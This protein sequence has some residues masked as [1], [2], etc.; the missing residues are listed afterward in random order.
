[1]AVATASQPLLKLLRPVL[2]ILLII[3]IAE[4]A[5]LVYFPSYIFGREDNSLLTIDSST[6]EI[7]PKPPI[8]SFQDTVDRSLFAPDRRPV[9]DTSVA[10]TQRSPEK[11]PVTERWILSGVVNTGDKVYAIFASV[12]LDVRLR[13]EIGM[14]LEK[15]KIAKIESDRVTVGEG[16]DQYEFYMREMEQKADNKAIPQRPSARSKALRKPETVNK[17]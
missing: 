9:A 5:L 16:D 15:W 7:L 10:P 13:L 2:M 12:D 6:E 11:G 8:A 17:Q 3:L 1:M 14:Y 4:F